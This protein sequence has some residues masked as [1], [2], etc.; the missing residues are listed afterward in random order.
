MHAH[1]IVRQ[2][3]AVLLTSATA[4]LHAQ[5]MNYGEMAGNNIGR[6]EGDDNIQKHQ[7]L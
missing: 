2:I 5:D 3:L 1:P 6:T 4:F 7:H